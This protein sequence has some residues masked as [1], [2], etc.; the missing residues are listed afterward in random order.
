MTDQPLVPDYELADTLEIDS[1]EQVQAI[2]HPLRTT[3]IGLLHERAATVS[4]LAQA[5]RRPK[6]TVAYHVGVLH[7]AGLLRVVRTRRVRAVEERSYG[8]NARMVSLG[9]GQAGP[10]PLTLHDFW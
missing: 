1:P 10:H 3:I 6:S 9:I 5:V 4:E 2:S 8:R 7:D